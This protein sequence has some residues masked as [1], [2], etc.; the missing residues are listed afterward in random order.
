MRLA[1]LFILLNFQTAWADYYSISKSDFRDDKVIMLNGSQEVV[2]K[3]GNVNFKNDDDFAGLIDTNRAISYGVKKILLH[4][5]EQLKNLNVYNFIYLLRNAVNDNLFILRT[6]KKDLVVK[7]TRSDERISSPLYPQKVDVIKYDYEA[8]HVLD[9]LDRL[10]DP[11]FEN[12]MNKYA[13]KAGNIVA[14]KILDGDELKVQK[15]VNRAL[16]TFLAEKKSRVVTVEA[17]DFSKEKIYLVYLSQSKTSQQRMN[18]TYSMEGKNIK[19]VVEVPISMLDPE[20]KTSQVAKHIGFLRDLNSSELFEMQ[21][22]EI[23]GGQVELKWLNNPKEKAVLVENRG[24]KELIY[25]SK[26]QQFYAFEGLLYLVSWM[27]ENAVEEK[28]ITYMNGAQPFDATLRSVGAGSYVMEKSGNTI[29]KFN[30]NALGIV[31]NIE[32]PAY[33]L[34]IELESVSNDSTKENIRFLKSY[35]FQNNIIM[36]KE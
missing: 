2:V 21:K 23:V 14:L 22:V 31:S 34:S 10:S 12:I 1:L 15:V 5:D 30:T 17:F 24:Q 11:G 18:V 4:E 27:K 16:N 26:R 13:D 8:L 19:S 3:N 20:K 28:I 6:G 25:K 32:Y 9:E 35:Q 36:V 7:T 33:D 29:Y